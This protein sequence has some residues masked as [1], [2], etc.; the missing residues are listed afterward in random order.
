M[1]VILV[2]FDI[3]TC[4]AQHL[5]E[6][7]TKV[8]RLVYCHPPNHSVF[9]AKLRQ[10]FHLE[11]LERELKEVVQEPENYEQREKI[12]SLHRGLYF[13][14][15]IK[16][17]EIKDQLRTEFEVMA[18]KSRPEPIEELPVKGSKAKLSGS[19][20]GALEISAENI[21]PIEQELIDETTI[22]KIRDSVKVRYFYPID[23]FKYVFNMDGKELNL[24]EVIGKLQT[25]FEE[26]CFSNALSA[27]QGRKRREAE[28]NSGDTGTSSRR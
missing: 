5:G 6:D 7:L 26:N 18:V 9:E 20:D 17:K 2:L 10:W 21:P 15:R 4:F 27:R 19:D 24:T 11:D 25:S 14:T 12:S 3:G 28:F 23:K 22:K 8:N 13:A 1:F 16:E